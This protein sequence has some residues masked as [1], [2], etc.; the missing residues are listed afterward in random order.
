MTLSPLSELPLIVFGSRRAEISAW[1]LAL[2][3]V[4]TRSDG[5]D[6]SDLSPILR[7]SMG[8]TLR[9]NGICISLRMSFLVN[10]PEPRTRGVGRLS[11]VRGSVLLEAE[12]DIFKDEVVHV[13]KN[14]LLAPSLARL[15]AAP[16]LIGLDIERLWE[17][18]R[19]DELR[20]GVES[21]RVARKL[22]RDEQ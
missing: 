19:K 9:I 17:A 1:L 16:V 21:R 15:L 13:E 10:D 18:S 12:L 20:Q 11:S 2:A 4:I 5:S 14:K 8:F 3:S 7:S 6:P 22:R